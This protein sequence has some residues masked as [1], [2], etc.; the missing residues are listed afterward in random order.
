MNI[1]HEIYSTYF[2]IASEILKLPHITEKSIYE[3]IKRDGFRDSVLFLPQKFIPQNDNSDWGLLIKK[4]NELVPVT[5]NKPVE[6]LTEIQKQWIK[7]ILDDPKIHLFLENNTIVS[8]KKR[9]ENVKPF[10]NRKHFRYTDKFSDGDNFCNQNYQANFR[11]IINAV[12]SHEILEITFI[13]GNGKKICKE[14]I[15]L[16]IQYSA[17]NDR[18]RFFCFSVENGEISTAGI[19]NIGRIKSIKPTGKYWKNNI[20]T[21]EYFQKRKCVNPVIVRISNERNA[22]ERF[23]MEFAPYE[24]CTLSDS[25]DGK[26]TV[27]I[28]YDY[29]E[30]T[31]LLI[32]LLS[33][34]AVIEILEPHRFRRQ[35]KKRITR[36]YDLLNKNCRD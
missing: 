19:I 34:G 14:Y 16:K 8:L 26:C 3:I 30:E 33:F 24:K 35:V 21:D 28:W 6:I 12:K 20:S 5:K 17:K 2:R 1:F 18:F 36:Q 4:N 9:L 13:S 23:F 10:Y 11:K 25:T 22:K 7:A 32:R 29:Q 27:K 15:P 31:E